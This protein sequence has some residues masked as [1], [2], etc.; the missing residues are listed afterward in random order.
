VGVWTFAAEGA[1]TRVTLEQTMAGAE[2]FMLGVL[3]RRTFR[4][5]VEEG[6]TR[7]ANYIARVPPEARV[8][9]GAPTAGATR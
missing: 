7:Y 2:G 8:A 9:A 5:E 6:I 4:R 3:F 1:G